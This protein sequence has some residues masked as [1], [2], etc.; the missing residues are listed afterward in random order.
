M[1]SALDFTKKS[2]LSQMLDLLAKPE[3]FYVALISFL[4]WKTKPAVVFGKLGKTFA[5][6]GF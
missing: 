4:N 2:V 6:A 1:C 3:S 5:F